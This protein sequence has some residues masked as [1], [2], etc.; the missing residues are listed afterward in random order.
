MPKKPPPPD[1]TKLR[2]LAEQ[3][4]RARSTAA[5]SP[6]TAADMQRLVHELQ[7][8][9]IELEMQND[10][11]QLA[12]DAMKAGLERYSG[13]FDFAPV[14]YLTLDRSGTVQDANLAAAGLLGIERSRLVHQRF[15]GH[16]A[17]SDLGGFDAFL[18]KVFVGEVRGFCEL[19]LVRDAPLPIVVRVEAAVESSG[20]ECRVVLV[21]ITGRKRAEE[22]RLTLNK[23]ESTGILAGGIAHDFNNLLTVILLDLEQARSLAAP[24]VQM[25]RHLDEAKK[26]ALSARS[27]TQQLV[28]FSKGGAPVRT[29]TRLD[30]VIRDS[31]RLPLSGS[32]VRCEMSL[33]GDLWSANVDE[34]QIGQVIRNLILNARE[35]MTNGGVISVRA[36]NV[37]IGASEHPQ[38]SPGDFV[39]LRVTD[40]GSGMSEEVRAKIYDPYYSTKQRGEEKG[41]GLGLTICHAIIQKHGGTIE[42]TSEVGVGTTFLVH[43]PACRDEAGD[44]KHVVGETAPSSARILVMDDDESVRKVIG[45]TLRRM[46]NEVE[47]VADGNT[48]IDRYRKATESG[49]P[50]DLVFLDLTVR[51]GMGGRETMLALRTF[52]PGVKGIVMSGYSEDIIVRDPGNHGFAGVLAKP[53][54]R[55]KL[56]AVIARVMGMRPER[57]SAS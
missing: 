18:E 9:Q 14:G 17:P 5:D 24:G 37:V 41:T 31:V 1:A 6:R 53:F 16:V 8:H 4:L 27:L 11:M 49:R 55:G 57:K 38:L 46:G 12:R 52:D 39:Q 19:T 32:R 36:G 50:F 23:L 28:T 48:A 15:G 30:G 45:L 22:D 43:L 42:V 35:A 51:A 40:R 21:D 3:R 10:Q 33:A 44:K 13:L 26:A 56:E 2:R 20:E 54:D 7:V 34:G 47:T 25:A 29:V